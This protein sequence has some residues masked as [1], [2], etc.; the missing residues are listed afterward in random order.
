[1]IAGQL[2][3]SETPDGHPLATPVSSHETAGDAVH[4]PGGPTA[5]QALAPGK[6]GT[7][8]PAPK[9]AQLTPKSRTPPSGSQSCSP[10]SSSHEVPDVVHA[11]GEPLHAALRPEEKQV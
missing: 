6:L 8:F 5:R 11:V 2:T 9:L 7:H 4:E 10:P 1:M 3:V